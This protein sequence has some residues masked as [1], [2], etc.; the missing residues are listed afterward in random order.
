MK[1]LFVEPDIKKAETLQKEF[2]LDPE[3]FELSKEK[4][5]KK[6]WQIIGNLEE[7]KAPSQIHPVRMLENFLDEPLILV[8]DKSDKLH[9]LS[10][11]CTH[12][13]NILVEGSCMMNNIRCRYHGRRFDLDGRFLSMPE[14]EETE[15]FPAEKDDLSK[16]PF[17]TWNDFIFASIDPSGPLQNFTGDM[18]SRMSFLADKNFIYDSS[19]SRDYL[20]NAHWALYCE[21]YL[22]GFHIP[23]VHPGL[24]AV[25]DY[26]D[27]ET[28][29][30]LLSN[31]QTGISK[32]G[33]NIFDLPA[34]HPDYGKNISAYYFWM[35][36]N[37]MFN[38]YPWGISVNVVNPVKPDLTK[39]SFLTYIS[40][41]SKLDKGAGSNLD[42][43]EREDEAIV[44][45]V[46]KGIRSSSYDRGRYSPKREI[47]THHFHRLICE[48]MK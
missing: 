43:V 37:L 3:F 22:E 35:F 1:E 12:R 11:V 6:S 46:Q 7:V 14:F 13:G 24:N 29:L 4:I 27:Y 28:E 8:R 2:Y 45:N 38:F 23:Y 33:E 21:N 41:E 40:D 36:P 16:I 5:F 39:V 42:K 48:F 10:N 31:L 30:F 15:N 34:D 32:G 9:C 26:S 20:V 17:N 47:G 25:L 19:R 44:E 18:F